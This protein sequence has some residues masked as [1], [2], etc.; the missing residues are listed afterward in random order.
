MLLPPEKGP[1]LLP[2]DIGPQLLPPEKGLILL[3]PQF[4]VTAAEATTVAI[5]I[6]F[7]TFFILISF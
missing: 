3:P 4:A 1:M 7:V 5:A 2:P 6:A